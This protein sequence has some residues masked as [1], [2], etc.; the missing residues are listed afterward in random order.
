MTTF[1]SLI[2]IALLLSILAG[3]V[4]IF[5]GPEPA[6]RMLAAQLFG[7]AAVAILLILSQLMALPALLDVAMVFALLAAITL[8]AFVVLASRGVR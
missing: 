7:T 6:E 2:L 3:L 1:L 5:R 8:V 4:R